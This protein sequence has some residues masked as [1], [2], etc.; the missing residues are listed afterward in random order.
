MPHIAAMTMGL[1]MPWSDDGLGFRSEV[2]RTGTSPK[3][4]PRSSQ[5]RFR[6]RMRVLR[7]ECCSAVQCQRFMRFELSLFRLISFFSTFLTM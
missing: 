2:R 5:F 6:P 1:Q 7:L 3:S 4:S